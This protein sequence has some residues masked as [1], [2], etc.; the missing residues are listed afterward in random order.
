ML[1]P[2]LP[3]LWREMRASLE[4]GDLSQAQA[5]GPSKQLWGF[6]FGDLW[7][8]SFSRCSWIEAKRWRSARNV[9]H[10]CRLRRSGPRP[11]SQPLTSHGCHRR[12]SLPLTTALHCDITLSARGRLIRTETPW[13]FSACRLAAWEAWRNGRGL[14]LRNG[15][16]GATRARSA[17]GWLGDC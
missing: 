16:G 14:G 12:F 3:N 15:R 10:W 4:R 11:F 13:A 7:Y 2:A 6:G 8:A 9:R 5:I 17:I 1:Q